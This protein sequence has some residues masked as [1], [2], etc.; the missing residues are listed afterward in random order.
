MLTFPIDVPKAKAIKPLERLGFRIVREGAH[1]AMV[2]QNPDET[3]TFLIIPN[4]SDL[5]GSTLR[6][7]CIQASIAR[8]EFLKAYEEM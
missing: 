2:R 5:R 7:I 4:H 3:Q 1:L 8:D 6:T